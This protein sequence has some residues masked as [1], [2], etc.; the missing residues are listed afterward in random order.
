MIFPLAKSS[1]RADA[2]GRFAAKEAVIKA[3]WDRHLTLHDIAIMYNRKIAAPSTEDLVQRQVYFPSARI[4]VHHEGEPTFQDALLSISHDRDYATAVCLANV[5]GSAAAMAE[6][7]D[8]GDVPDEAS[9][10]HRVL[11]ESSADGSDVK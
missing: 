7:E 11:N 6:G 8:V 9:N 10:V 4:L 3:Y 1:Y 2:G 5:T